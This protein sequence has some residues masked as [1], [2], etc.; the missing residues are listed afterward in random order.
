[1]ADLG[2]TPMTE[3]AKPKGGWVCLYRSLLT[4]EV[5]EDHNLTRVFLWCLLK[6]NHKPRDWRGQTIP[7][8]SFVTSTPKAASEIDLSRTVIARAL[9]RL[10]ARR[11]IVTQAAQRYTLVSICNYETYQQPQV[12]RGTKPVQ[13]AVQARYEGG[14]SAVQARYEGGHKQ[15]VT[16]NNPS[17]PNRTETLRSQ[18][19][20]HPEPIQPPA[21]PPV[22][23][24]P[25]VA[26]A[27][28]VAQPDPFLEHLA[29]PWTPSDDPPPP[30]P[31]FEVRPVD[32]HIVPPGVVPAYDPNRLAMCRWAD[33][34]PPAWSGV[35]ALKDV[36]VPRARMP[37]S[38]DP[39]RV[40]EWLRPEYLL[41]DFR[42]SAN[43]VDWFRIS[44]SAESPIFMPHQADLLF[45]L[46]CHA[47]M[48]KADH[49]IL[50]R[51]GYFAKLCTTQTPEQ[52][53][54]M[55]RLCGG[56]MKQIPRW[57]EQSIARRPAV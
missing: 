57:V 7:R 40:F 11:M 3:K 38:C 24:P 4:S 43:V 31:R 21:P 42:G 16:S 17:I 52:F 9:K 37:R 28:S 36:P 8:G 56:I 48:G 27:A 41:A 34:M 6:A 44:L 45:A 39:G 19:Q 1:M 15:Q 54:V 49:R 30:A 25:A 51:V 2:T 10:A 23:P 50:N 5:W 46:C 20:T 13:R 32:T 22:T 12:V 55:G 26:P 18:P 47:V 14:T 33:N 53:R 29:I 35:L